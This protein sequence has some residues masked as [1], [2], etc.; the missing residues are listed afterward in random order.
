MD[1]KLW[2]DQFDLADTE[3]ETTTKKN[4]E[5]QATAEKERGAPETPVRH[6]HRNGSRCCSGAVLHA[7][8]NVA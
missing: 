1:P 6:P 2:V 8:A 5:K 3:A 4:A 7:T